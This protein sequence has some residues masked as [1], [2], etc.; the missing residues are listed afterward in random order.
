MNLGVASISKAC[1]KACYKLFCLFSR[2]DEVLFVSRKSNEPCANFRA[3]GEEF[4][5]RGWRTKCLTK[6]LSKR[7]VLSYGLH[8]VRELYYLARCRVCVLDRYDPVVALLDFE[9]ESDPCSDGVSVHIE[10]PRQP[11][12]LQLWHAFGAFKKFGFQS[13]NTP[14]GH[15]EDVAEAFGIHRNY[16]WIICTGEND[17]AVFSEAFSYP[18]DR[19]IALGLPQYDELVAI[20]KRFAAITSCNEERLARVLFAPTLRKSDES[21]HPFRELQQLW[22]GLDE[23]ERFEVDWSFHPIETGVGASLGVSEALLDADYVVTDYSS[24]VYEAYVLGKRVV[25][26]TPD[27]E[28]YRRSPGLNADPV[29][30]SPS[31]SF[32]D[33]DSLL[34]FLSDVTSGNIPYP[35]EELDRFVG[36]TFDGCEPGVSSR[37]VDFVVSRC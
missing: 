23:R 26:Y 30:L 21:A 4:E 20:E 8:V 6:L 2:R 3:I 18:I 24:I 13:L 5:R 15:N 17:R 27:I 22:D 34:E 12:V 35:Q 33:Q 37:I 16:S 11:V 14:E 9:C 28:A 7:S 29:A 32:L 25:F 31:L 19:V 1:F 10:Y 36:S